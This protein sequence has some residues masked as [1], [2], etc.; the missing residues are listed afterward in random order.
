MSIYFFCDGTFK[1]CPDPF[2]Q[3]Y[4]ILGKYKELLVP[5][6]YCFL[7]RKNIDIYRE[8]FTV[9]KTSIGDRPIAMALDLELSV[10]SNLKELFGRSIDIR[11]CFFHI[12]CQLDSQFRE[13]GLKGV[14]PKEDAKKL[15]LQFS[16]CASS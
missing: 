5:L 8:I 14:L 4:I 15:L 7:P 6:Y 12:R 13:K 9:L 2:A 11:L 3:V 1:S 10:D 16:V